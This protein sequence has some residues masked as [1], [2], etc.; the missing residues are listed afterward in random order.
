MTNTIQA[1]FP[2]L[3]VLALLLFG[4]SILN[5]HLPAELSGMMENKGFILGLYE[6]VG[7]IARILGPLIIFTSLF[8]QLN[9]IYIILGTFAL[10]LFIVHLIFKQRKSHNL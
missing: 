7:S 2:S 5:T 3:F 4:I 1:L 10:L 6:S 8:K 9:Q